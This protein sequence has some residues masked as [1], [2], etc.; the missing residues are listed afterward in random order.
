MD[1]AAAQHLE[2]AHEFEVPA[3]R[4]LTHLA[5][6]EEPPDGHRALMLGRSRNV[7]D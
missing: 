3:E 4:L 7:F 6:L 2:F 5:R 1:F